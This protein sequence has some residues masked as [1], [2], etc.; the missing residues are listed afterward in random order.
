MII[1]YPVDRSISAA[2][3]LGPPFA[4]PSPADSANFAVGAATALDVEFF[5]E[6]DIPGARSRFPLNSSL[7]VQLDWFDSLKTWLWRQTT[8]QGTNTSG[9]RRE[10]VEGGDGWMQI[11]GREVLG[12]ALFI[13]GEFGVNDYHFSFQRKGVPEVRSCRQGHQHGDRGTLSLES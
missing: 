11:A 9:I 8:T 10:F 13:V 3:R 4:S 7:S 5:R 6:R 2:E 1:S 12:R